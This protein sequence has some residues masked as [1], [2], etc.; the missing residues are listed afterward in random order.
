MQQLAC[1]LPLDFNLTIF[2]I[3]FL[4]V[5]CC[6]FGIENKLIRNCNS[7]QNLFLIGIIISF[8]S[9]HSQIKN[10]IYI[11]YTYNQLRILFMFNVFIAFFLFFLV[12]DFFFLI[13]IWTRQK[14][15]DK[16]VEFEMMLRHF[17]YK[18]QHKCARYEWSGID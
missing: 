11:Q 8:F 14:I 6:I 18:T 13:M 10:V 1:T 4:C 12:N 17:S 16:C 3:F 15:Y 9:V 2:K 7:L 5:L